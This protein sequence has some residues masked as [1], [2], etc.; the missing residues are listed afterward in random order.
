MAYLDGVV[1]AVSPCR[2]VCLLSGYLSVLVAKEVCGQYPQTA[3][4]LEIKLRMVQLEKS[5]VSIYDLVMH[6]LFLLRGLCAA[7]ILVLKSKPPSSWST[8][9]CLCLADILRRPRGISIEITNTAS[10]V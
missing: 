9:P 6:A 8:H 4:M 10:L 7:H 1:C 3:W 5:W 2:L